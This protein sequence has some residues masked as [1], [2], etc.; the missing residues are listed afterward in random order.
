[1]IFG[2][3][4]LVVNLGFIIVIYNGLDCNF[5]IFLDDLIDVDCDGVYILLYIDDCLWGCNI[6]LFFILLVYCFCLD[7]GEVLF[8]WFLGLWNGGDVV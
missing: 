8:V 3:C 5:F 1:M 7:I 4:F 2:D 6:I